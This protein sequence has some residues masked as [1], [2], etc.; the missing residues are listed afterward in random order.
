MV[1]IW[2]SFFKLDRC[3]TPFRCLT[4]AYV[5]GSCQDVLARTVSIGTVGAAEADAPG[6]DELLQAV[7]ADELLEGVH[8]LRRAGELEDDRV[9]AEIGDARVEH[10]GEPDQLLAPRRRR[11]DLDQR[12]LAL[13][14]LAGRE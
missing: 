10:V 13:H 3:Q 12:E 11:G 9:G 5:C 1:A 4:P 14:R 8:V 7:R 2:C 6:A